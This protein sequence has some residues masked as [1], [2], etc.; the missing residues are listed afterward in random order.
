MAFNKD[1][2][3]RKFLTLGDRIS[4]AVTAVAG[5]G[6][7]LLFNSVF[8]VVW[9]MINTG[10]FGDNLIFDEY[11]FGLLTTAVSLEAIILSIFVLITQKRQAKHSRLRAEL[12]YRTDL[13]AEAEIKVMITMLERLAKQQNVPVEDLVAELKTHYKK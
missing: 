7:F 8:F 5:S 13:R 3:I 9:L 10:Q 1:E 11:P 6:P 4:D 2:E 12:D